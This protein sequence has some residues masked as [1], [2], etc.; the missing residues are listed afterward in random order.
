MIKKITPQ[1][2]TAQYK[3]G[4]Y[5]YIIETQGGRWYADQRTNQEI[6]EGCWPDPGA[7]CKLSGRIYTC[8]QQIKSVK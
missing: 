7:D 8:R 3:C 1:L 5:R 6:Q 2:I 4:L